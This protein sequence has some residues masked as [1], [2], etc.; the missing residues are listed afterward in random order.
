[1]T[2][3]E[4]AVIGAGTVLTQNAPADQLTLAR[5]QQVTVEDWS[6]K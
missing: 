5:A 1:V 6:K 3:G 2:I 4:N